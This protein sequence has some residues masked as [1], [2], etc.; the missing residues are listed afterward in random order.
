M[1]RQ[2]V[3]NTMYVVSDTMYSSILDYL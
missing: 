2:V 1:L 3:L